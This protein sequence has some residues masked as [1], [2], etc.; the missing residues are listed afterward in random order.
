VL[1]VDTQTLQQG[2]WRTRHGIRLPHEENTMNRIV[3]AGSILLALALP[4]SADVITLNATVD[5]V[6]A[7]STS[8]NTGQLDVTGVALGPFS[9]N[10][11]TADSKIVLPF[12][13][14]LNTNTLNLQQ[15][16]TGNH[17]LILDI[18]ASSLSGPGLLQSILST[19]S[20]SGLTT[21]WNAQEQ[22]FIN[23]TLLADTGVFTNPSD[24]AT[25]I[26]PAFLGGTFSA[27]VK[28]TINSVG[29]GGFNGGIDISTAAVPGPIAGAG[30][31]GLVGACFTM[32]GLYRRRRLRA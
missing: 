22:T 24:S 13:G 5:G 20:V 8:S 18:I 11:I 14:I 4:A 12:P 21:G 29:I 10:T 19:F 7:G 30:I 3:L 27:E 16:D 26:N 17:S 28:Y 2:S 31:P 25:S 9:L 23:G 32:L 6:A 1:F 15:S